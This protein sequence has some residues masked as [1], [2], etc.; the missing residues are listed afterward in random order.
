MTQTTEKNQDHREEGTP[1]NAIPET[2]VALEAA[3]T[4]LQVAQ[5]A[6]LRDAREI[7]DR[8]NGERQKLIK[9]PGV[10]FMPVALSVTGGQGAFR[11]RWI[12]L[13]YRDGKLK[14]RKD[15]PNQKGEKAHL[16]TI[17][18]K[19]PEEFHAA[20][21]QAE[22]EL[23]VLRRKAKKLTDAK[24]LVNDTLMIGT[25]QGYATDDAAPAGAPYEMP[26]F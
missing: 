8:F 13:V 1:Q 6:V 3:K 24:G 18:G 16:G 11:A 10:K 2:T 17:K 7:A 9:M 26:I 5:D 12:E 21:A 19:S 14:L 15:L 23:R 4:A 20:I 22:G 25:A